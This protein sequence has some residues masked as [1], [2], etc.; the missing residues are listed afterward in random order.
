M[1]SRP[2]TVQT[3]AEAFAQALFLLHV[4]QGLASANRVDNPGDQ[5][6]YGVARG[7]RAVN[8]GGA[9]DIQ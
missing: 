1:R 3:A 8:E 4:E 7:V 9:D 5:S 2:T 6:A